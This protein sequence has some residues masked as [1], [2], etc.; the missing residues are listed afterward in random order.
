MS[1]ED[2]YLTTYSLQHS[3][4]THNQPIHL[5]GAAAAHHEIRAIKQRLLVFFFFEEAGSHC[6]SHP[7]RTTSSKW[8]HAAQV[9]TSVGEVVSTRLIN[10]D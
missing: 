4:T 6:C 9:R 5:F 10:C 2:V 3:H 1:E 8:R 7:K